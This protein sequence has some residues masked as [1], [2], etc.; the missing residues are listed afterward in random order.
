MN[1]KLL[2]GG[3]AV[4]LAGVALYRLVTPA[5]DIYEGP[6][7]AWTAND[8]PDLSG[9]VIVVTGGNSGIG[10]EAAKEFARKGAHVILACRNMEKAR[11]AMEEIVAE[12]PGASIEIMDLDLASLDS[13]RQFA[14][15]FKAQHDRLDILVN[16][17][18][19]MMV[20][21][22]KTKDGFES[23]FGVNHLGHFALTGLLLE[24]LLATPGARVVTISSNAHTRG[25]MDFTDLGFQDGSSYDRSAAYNRSKLANLLFTQELQHRFAE[26]GADVIAVAAHPGI[27]A[28]HLAD[29]LIEGPFIDLARPLA[30]RIFQSAAMGALPTLRAAVDP[31]AQ[32]GDYYG[33]DGFNSFRGYPVKIAASPAAQ[34]AADARRLWDVSEHLTGVTYDALQPRESSGDHS[35]QA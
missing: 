17:A 15:A 1:R 33:P 6:A 4:A 5:E 35:Q 26:S 19:I 3:A 9:K 30:G 25:E 13:V 24:P 10:F 20:P 21:Y 31:S 28:T 12:M 29:H 22:G 14:A 18:G 16:N 27:S 2:F 32:G 34:D 23:Q 11:S 8:M 7:G